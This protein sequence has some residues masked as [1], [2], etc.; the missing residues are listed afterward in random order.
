[1]NNIRSGAIRQQ[2]PNFLSDGNSTVCSIS[3]SL[4]TFARYSKNKK[5]GTTL[6]WKMTVKVIES[7]H[8]T[9]AIRL[10]MSE[11]I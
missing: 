10:E 1:M 4:S 2:I 9:S 5:N 8:G 6:T 3:I 11:T 7:N